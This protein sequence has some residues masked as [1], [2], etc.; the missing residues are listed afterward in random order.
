MGDDY[1][2]AYSLR[3][4]EISC[5]WK[6][7]VN[8]PPKKEEGSCTYSLRLGG[9]LFLEGVGLKEF[10]F[11]FSFSFLGGIHEGYSYI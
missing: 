4:G 8:I 5:I 9:I 6:A 7:H 10:G 3:W 11:T 1:S 2:Y